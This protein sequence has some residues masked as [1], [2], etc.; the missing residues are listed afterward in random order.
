MPAQ[1]VPLHL[2]L[3]SQG[4]AKG[5]RLEQDKEERQKGRGK[6]VGKRTEAL[7]RVVLGEGRR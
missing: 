1:G 7:A 5:E 2:L 4:G 6:C 3:G